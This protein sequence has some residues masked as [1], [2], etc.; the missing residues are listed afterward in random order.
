[1]YKALHTYYPLTNITNGEGAGMSVDYA[2][3]LIESNEKYGYLS[4]EAKEIF[5]NIFLDE[6]L[7]CVGE[8]CD[9]ID[10]K[11]QRVIRNVDVIDETGYLPI[12]ESYAPLTTPKVIASTLPVTHTNQ[13]KNT[14]Q[15][16]TP[17]QPSNVKIQYVV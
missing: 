12:T 7:G 14:V 17:T 9:Y 1:M 16:D 3:V 11:P 6:P 5:Y 10:F 8:Y 4:D 2:V 13:M 15:I